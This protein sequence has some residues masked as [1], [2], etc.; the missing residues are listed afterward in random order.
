MYQVSSSQSSSSSDEQTTRVSLFDAANFDDVEAA[1]KFIAQGVDV[2]ALSTGHTEWGCT[3]L[4]IAANS[5]CANVAKLLLEHGANPLIGFK[6][7]HGNVSS[8]AIGVAEEFQ[9]KALSAA[10]SGNTEKWPEAIAECKSIRER[11]ERKYRAQFFSERHV[12]KQYEHKGHF[13][14][15]HR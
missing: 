15:S 8:T 4:F 1:Q 9:Y 3:A 11:K 13:G 5:G 2:N 14:L 10:L 7:F 12:D 6:D